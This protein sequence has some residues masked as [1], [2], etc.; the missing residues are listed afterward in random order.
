MSSLRATSYIVGPV[1][2]MVGET[3][4]PFGLRPL[5]LYNG[6][7]S[8]QSLTGKIAILRLST[9]NFHDDQ[10]MAEEQVYTY[11]Y[12]HMYMYVNV[13]IALKY[14]HVLYQYFVFMYDGIYILCIHV[15]MYIYLSSVETLTTEKYIP[16]KVHVHVHV[17]VYTHHVLVHIFFLYISLASM[18]YS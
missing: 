2:S 10:D 15:C 13:N 8:C 18:L 1:C 5:M 14:I 16:K 7:V 12:I 17:H 6:E 3:K 4:L 11:M 9:H